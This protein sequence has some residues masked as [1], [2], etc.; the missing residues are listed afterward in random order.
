MQAQDPFQPGGL[1]ARREP[2]QVGAPPGRL[3]SW[4]IRTAHFN[5][6][7]RRTAIGE[8]VSSPKFSCFGR[9]WEVEMIPGELYNARAN[10]AFYSYD[11]YISLAIHNRSETA[12]EAI[13][14]E[15]KYIIKHPNGGPDISEGSEKLSKFSS[16]S[17][18]DC[19][20]GPS[21]ADTYF[22]VRSELMKYLIDGTLIVE[23]HMRANESAQFVPGNPILQYLLKD[24]NNDDT[25]DVKLEVGGSIEGRNKRQK[26]VTTTFYAHHY[27]LR[28]SAP[29]L[30]DMCEPRERPHHSKYSCCVL[31]DNVEPDIFKLLLRYCYGGNI[32]K[33][34]LQT[35]AQYIID[36]ADRFGVVNLKLEAEACYVDTMELT[37]DNLVE[38]VNYADSKNLALLKER[39]MEFLSSADKME[40]AKKVSFAD[41]PPHLMKDLMVSLA[42]SEAKTGKKGDLEMMCVSGLR[43]LAHEKGLDV[44]GSR[45]MLI[46]SIEGDQQDPS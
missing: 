1:R 23:V 31:I 25:A 16:T 27:I 22:A 10:N 44:D 9:Q 6:F 37:L 7:E 35:N 5:E 46:A 39:C 11:R 45:E 32:A 26:T 20:V 36:A 34:D 8:A 40:V 2:L 42:R 29:A 21:Q 30:A 19:D 15:H 41:M 3:S 12:E 43:K 17:T 18:R 4:M 14:V 33:E 28:L 24:F 13:E 38:A